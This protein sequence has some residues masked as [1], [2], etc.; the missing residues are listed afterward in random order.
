MPHNHEVEI[1][2][3]GEGTRESALPFTDCEPLVGYIGPELQFSPGDIL[4]INTC[5]TR[6]QWSYRTGS[7]F[8]LNPCDYNIVLGGMWRDKDGKLEAGVSSRDERCFVAR[9]RPNGGSPFWR[10]WRRNATQQWTRMATFST[11]VL[12][13]QN[14]K[15]V[16]LS[17]DDRLLAL[18]TGSGTI[19]IFSGRTLEENAVIET[20]RS[21]ESIDFSPNGKRLV[22]V[23]AGENGTA[24]E[25]SFWDLKTG[26]VLQRDW[27]AEPMRCA[28]YSPKGD[29]VAA[30][31]GQSTVVV[32]RVP[33][34]RDR[35]PV[36]R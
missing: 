28:T 6:L 25:M 14:V 17:K 21:V 12:G 27:A 19:H 1:W 33:G 2:N 31:E 30:V 16:W 10:V 35:P 3:V 4:T 5:N 24:G 26:H 29:W 20:A 22:A 11:S 15:F 36:L 23:G 34:A 7:V 32:R 9:V 18:V 8:K 13:G